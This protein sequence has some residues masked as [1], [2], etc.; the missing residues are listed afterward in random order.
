MLP[1][2][3]QLPLL[4]KMSVTASCSQSVEQIIRLLLQTAGLKSK[5]EINRSSYNTREKHLQKKWQ[6]EGNAALKSRLNQW[7]Y[8]SAVAGGSA[9]GSGGQQPQSVSVKKS[10]NRKGFEGLSEYVFFLDGKYIFSESYSLNKTIIF[11]WKAALVH[12]SVTSKV[13]I[14][15]DWPIS[16]RF[17][18]LTCFSVTWWGFLVNS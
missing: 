15:S 1:L 11:N 12:L 3:S 17:N 13:F 5:R 7:I 16:H 6:R 4:N 14:H 8:T 10:A 18:Y 2:P 9:V